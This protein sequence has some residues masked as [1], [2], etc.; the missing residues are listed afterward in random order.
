[1]DARITEVT[2]VYETG[3]FQLEAT[4]GNAQPTLITKLKQELWQIDAEIKR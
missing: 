1:M 2:E 3:G 4:F